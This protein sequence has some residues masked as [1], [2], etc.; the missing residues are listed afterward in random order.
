MKQW[1]ALYVFL[2][3]YDPLQH[4]TTYRDDYQSF[5][6]P[7]IFSRVSYDVFIICVLEKTDCVIARF[8]FIN[9]L[10]FHCCTRDNV[11]SFHPI[12]IHNTT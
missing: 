2:Y 9:Q 10:R 8:H 4:D 7:K 6:L 3:S 5:E 11:W 1:S 12:Y